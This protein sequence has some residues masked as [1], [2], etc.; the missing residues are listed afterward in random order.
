MNETFDFDEWEQHDDGLEYEE[1]IQ[2][3]YDQL[4]GWVQKNVEVKKKSAE[5]D[6]EFR[7]LRGYAKLNGIDMTA[8]IFPEGCFVMKERRCPV[9]KELL[10]KHCEGLVSEEI[11]QQLF[12]RIKAREVR[13]Y[14]VFQQQRKNRMFTEEE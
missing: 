10:L 13:R 1:R 12:E 6:A 5:V 4:Q 3:F 9:T 8:L 14:Q 11:L 2:D 7:S